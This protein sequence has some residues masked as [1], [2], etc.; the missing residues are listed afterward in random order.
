MKIP[1]PVLILTCA[2]IIC[3]IASW[4]ILI[5][6]QVKQYWI[7]YITTL[8]GTITITTPFTFSTTYVATINAEIGLWETYYTVNTDFAN[9]L[10][11]DSFTADTVDSAKTDYFD[12]GAVIIF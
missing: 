4:S 9:A 8:S 10:V 5:V 2:G 11:P 7:Y 1:V 6:C 3:G 12:E